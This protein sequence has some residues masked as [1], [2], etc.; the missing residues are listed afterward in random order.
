MSLTEIE[1]H[2]EKIKDLSGILET[3]A[4]EIKKLAEEDGM[5]T[6]SAAKAAWISEN[7]DIFAG[8][9]IK[10]MGRICETAGN[11]AKLSEDMRKQAQRL[12]EKEN[13]NTL[14]AR[15]RTY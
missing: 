4:E 11:L 10:V 3:A 1:I 14:T 15:A 8:K 13:Q 7:A 5:Q 9:E 6:I 12:Y 2:F